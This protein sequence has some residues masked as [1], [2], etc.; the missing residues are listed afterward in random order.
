MLMLG[1]WPYRNS[2]GA[3]WQNGPSPPAAALTVAERLRARGYAT[4]AVGKWHLGFTGGRHPLDQG[5]D[6][7]FGFK[8]IT[9]DYY[10]HDPQ[11]PLYRN[12]T[13]IR[14]TGYVTDTLADEAVRILQARRTTPLFLYVSMMAFHPPLQ[15]TLTFAVQRVDVALGRIVAAARV[16][17]LSNC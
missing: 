3:I 1:R 9:P 10:G 17:T 2:A 6:Q 5:F 16:R 15:T 4:A 13:E 14:N 8:G 11:A 12:R 7:F